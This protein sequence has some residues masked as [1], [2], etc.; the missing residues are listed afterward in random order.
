MRLSIGGKNP[1]IDQ[2][3][4]LFII[5]ARS[6]TACALDPSFDGLICS[7]IRKNNEYNKI[8]KKYIK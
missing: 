5:S 8:K 2:I 7:F 3:R 1:K 6:Y 4:R